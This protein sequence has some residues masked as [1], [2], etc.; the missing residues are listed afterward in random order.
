MVAG[1]ITGI[2]T[3]VATGAL[4][5]LLGGGGSILAVPSLVY[6]LGMDTKSAIGTSLIIVGAASLLA[7]LAHFKNKQVRLGTAF[8]FGASGGVGSILGAMAGRVMPDQIQLLLFALL[9]ILIAV[10]MLRRREAASTT[11]R[12]GRS[13]IAA[14]IGAGAVAGVLTGLLGVGGGFVI[15]PALTLVIG[16]PVKQAIGTSLV[17]IGI[18]SLVG[19]SAYGGYVRLDGNLI[20]F[21]AGALVAAPAAGH[22][23]QRIEP[24]R[25]RSGFA[26]L[27]LVLSVFMLAKQFLSF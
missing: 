3:G 9:M 14:I 23:A 8:S 6:A 24:D 5:G 4:L 22:L 17:I 15:V 7:A 16:L 2:L 21:A 13:R 1:P 25:L 20:P 19:A 10:L 18:N 27:L 26:C 12:A 11:A